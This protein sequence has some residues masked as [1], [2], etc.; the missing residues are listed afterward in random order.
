LFDR[1]RA[2][3]TGMKNERM[4]KRTSKTASDQM[5]PTYD[6]SGGIRG[7]Y[8]ERYRRGNNAVLLDPE[9]AAAFPDSAAARIRSVN[10]HKKG[11]PE[12]PPL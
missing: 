1:E 12:G 8:V 3:Q 6:F 2:K 5:R 9:I 4:G 10:K 7:K 11:G